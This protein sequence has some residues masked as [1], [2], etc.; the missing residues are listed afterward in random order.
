M[1][2]MDFMGFLFQTGE[3]NR[4]LKVAVTLKHWDA[5]SLEDSDGYTRHNFNAIISNATLADTYWPAFKASVV[6]GGARG[7]MCS[8][9]AV[10]GVPTCANAFLSSVLRGQWGFAGYITSDSGALEDIYQQHHYVKT[11]QEVSAALQMYLELAHRRLGHNLQAACVAIQNG[12]CDVCS[13]AV[14]HD[15]LLQVLHSMVLSL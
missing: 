1:D 7:V 5:Y 8:Y 14:Y 12:T 2:I 6:T 10:N 4:F 11:E 9:N 13:G 15:A 3:D